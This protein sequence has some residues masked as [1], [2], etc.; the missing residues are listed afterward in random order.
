MQSCLRLFFFFKIYNYP[1][2]FKSLCYVTWLLQ[3]TY[4]RTVFVEW[5]ESEEH[6]FL[7][8]KVESENSSQCL[9]LQWTTTEAAHTPH[10]PEWHHHQAS[11]Q[12][13]TRSI[14]LSATTA[15]NCVCEHLCFI[16]I[17]QESLKDVI[18]GRAL[19]I[20]SI[21]IN[22]NCFFALYHFWLTEDFIG[23]LYFGIVGE[24]YITKESILKI[25]HH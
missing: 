6:S 5:K 15:L 11:S 18:L 14:S 1:L 10:T 19:K 25:L 20:F 13:T 16:S 3:K 9:F 7:R 4:I 23:M 2:L 24:A 21:W 12:G 8:R 17:Y 22:G